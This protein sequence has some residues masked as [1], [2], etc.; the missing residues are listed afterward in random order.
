MNGPTLLLFTHPTFGVLAIMASVWV[1]VEALN[2]SEANAWRI[3]LG[4]M[5]RV[6]P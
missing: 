1:F 3:R 4:G 6:D 5:R 2:A